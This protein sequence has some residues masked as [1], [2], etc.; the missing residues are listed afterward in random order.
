[1]N[2]PDPLGF[3]ADVEA[4][5]LLFTSLLVQASSELLAHGPQVDHRG[6]SRTRSFRAAFWVAYATRIGQRL[7]EAAQAAATEAATGHGIEVLPVLA[8]REA[9]VQE[10]FDAAF[11]RI[12]TRSVRVSNGAG[13]HAGRQAADR[14]DLGRQSRIGATR[15]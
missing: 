12:V 5:E 13:L 3:A 2:V 7:T 8:S 10:A 11:P 15:W 6:R 9:Q 1:M 14:A 4:T